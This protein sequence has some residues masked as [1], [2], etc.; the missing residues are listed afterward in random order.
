MKYYLITGEASGDLH[1]ANLM[2]SLKEFDNQARFRFWGG[3]KMKK[4]DGNLA[5]HF[6]DISFM[7]F[8]EV[9]KHLDTIISSL[10]FCKRDVL[11]FA[12]DAL[13]LID[14]PGF[15]L[16]IASWAKNKGMSVFYYISPQVWA[17]KPGRIQKIKETVDQMYV[18][19]SF[20]KDFYRQYSYD[21]EFVGHPLLDEIAAY[22]SQDNFR[23]QSKLSEAPIIALLPGSRKQEIQMILPKMLAVCHHFPGYQFVIGGLSNH[24]QEFYHHIL[25]KVDKDIPVCLDNT[26][27]LLS[28]AYAALVTS[29]TATLETAIFN[30]PQVVVY[31]GSAV[32]Y[33]IARRLVRVPY[34]SLVNLIMEK[35]VVKE[36]I[37]RN[38]NTANLRV[39]LTE[40]LDD[41]SR[42]RVLS[43][44]AILR[45]K[46]GESGASR[47]TANLIYTYLRNQ[48]V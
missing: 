14:F 5:K 39:S 29:G 35:A 11:Q 7:G 6:K 42:S 16:R 15:N 2:H 12:P 17:W 22:Q 13:I 44:Y 1:G 36:L 18:I 32:S 43:E 37:Q 45:E 23:I 48:N 38:F 46:L 24:G 19:L 3:D 21:V 25:S 30:V 4:E 8:W 20:E 26:Y 40:I 41:H 34:I 31:A 28:E 9:I 27:A 47:R 33:W 10:N